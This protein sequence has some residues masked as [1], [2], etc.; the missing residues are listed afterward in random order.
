[1][2]PEALKKAKIAA[3]VAKAKAKKAAQKTISVN[4]QAVSVETPPSVNSDVTVSAPQTTLASNIEPLASVVPASEEM[5]P[6]ALKKAKIA[7]AVAK[8][9]AKKRANSAKQEEQ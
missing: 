4:T 8:A 9:K 6:E 5:T 7:A 1:M 2:T 3:A